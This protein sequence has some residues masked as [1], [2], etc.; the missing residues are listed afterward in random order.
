MLVL[1]KKE[2]YYI[3][4][5]WQCKGTRL[6][7]FFVCTNKINWRY[8]LLYHTTHPARCTV[9]TSDWVENLVMVKL[10]TAVQYTCKTNVHPANYAY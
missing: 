2:V 6:I 7:V 10:Q 5:K 1:P 9:G 8:V 4:I 3:Y